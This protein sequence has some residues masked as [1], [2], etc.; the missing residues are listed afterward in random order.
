MPNSL[1]SLRLVE[2]ATMCLD[3]HSS[4]SWAMSHLRTVRAFSIVSAVV[5]VLDTTT[6]MVSAGSSF[7]SARATSIGSTFARKRSS[8]PWAHFAATGSVLRAVCTNRGPRKE[9]PM[10]TA[11]T[12][13]IGKPVW[14]T[15]S[16]LRTLSVKDL[17]RSKTAHTS[18]TT[19]FPLT[20]TFC[21]RRERVATCSTG[22]SSVLFMGSPVN[23]SSILCFRLLASANLLSSPM[24]L[25]VTC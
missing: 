7:L 25:A 5:K 3:T 23:M 15:H 9:P 8:R 17:M 2:T 10:P 19:F 13:L 16:P 21:S 6:T 12:F 11:T 18:G 20:I 22:R 14:P 24:V 4:P 1:T